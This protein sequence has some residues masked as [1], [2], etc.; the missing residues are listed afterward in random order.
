MPTWPSL[1]PRPQ[2]TGYGLN[3]ADQ[4]VRT[5]MEVGT[6]RSRRRT[7]SRNDQITVNWLFTDAQMAVF[8]AFFDGDADGGSAWFSVDLAFGDAGLRNREARFI[9]PW[10][11]TPT[12]GLNWDVTA[13]LETRGGE[14]TADQLKGV[15]MGLV[16]LSGVYPSLVLDFA[17]DK[18]LDSRITFTRASVGTYWDASGVLRTAASG[19]ARFDHDPVTHESLGLLI[20]EQRTNLLTYSAE[21]NNAAW[22]K[23]N[24]TVTND[25]VV[26]PDGGTNADVVVEAS[27][28]FVQFAFSESKSITASATYTLSMYVKRAAG[29]GRGLRLE[30]DGSTDGFRANFNPDTGAVTSTS[31]FGSGVH[32]ASGSVDVGGGWRRYYVTGTAGAVTSAGFTFRFTSTPTGSVIGYTGDGVQSFAVW[33]AQLEAGSFPTSYIP[34]TTGSVQRYADVATMAG[35]NFTNWFSSSQG[36]FFASAKTSAAGAG[37]PRLLGGS[38]AMSGVLFT[39]TSD[40]ASVGTWNNAHVLNNNSSAGTFANGCKAAMSYSPTGRSVTKGGN[41]VVSDAYP[42][43]EGAYTATDLLIGSGGGAPLNGTIYRLAYYPARLPNPDLQA[44]TA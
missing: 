41:A 43:I 23:T 37:N 22:T 21:I 35:A 15:V 33:G 2:I 8:R 31:V 7:A 39:T 5:D 36:S 20:E 13:K 40:P 1:L 32:V 28:A 17:G 42:L 27:G 25:A 34:T 10:Q 30:V 24:V 4:T 9:G 3:P 11:A 26:S 6:A 29:T 14:L 38:S 16:S 12:G 44:L 19:E 18:A